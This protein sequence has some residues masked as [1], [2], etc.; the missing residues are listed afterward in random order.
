MGDQNYNALK[1]TPPEPT[2]FLGTLRHVVNNLNG[3]YDLATLDEKWRANAAPPDANNLN[4]RVSQFAAP[5]AMMGP[6][7]DRISKNI[8]QMGLGE[9]LLYQLNWLPPRMIMG[10]INTVRPYVEDPVTMREIGDLLPK[11]R[12]PYMGPPKR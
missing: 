12:T 8:E 10:A 9:A 11:E 7:P 5:A 4:G 6:P 2:D 3:P 1:P